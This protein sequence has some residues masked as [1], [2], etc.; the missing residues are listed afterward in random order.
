MRYWEAQAKGGDPMAQYE[1][2]KMQSSLDAKQDNSEVANLY[3]QAADQGIPGAARDLGVLYLQGNGVPQNVSKALKLLE[4]AAVNGDAQAS[5][6]MGYLYYTGARSDV[7]DE[8]KV[9][10]NAIVEMNRTKAEYFFTQAALKD[11]PESLFYLGEMQFDGKSPNNV[12]DDEN[13]KALRYYQR[14]ADNGYIRAFW[15]E[16]KLYENGAKGV[17]QSCPMAVEGYKTVAEAGRGTVDVRRGLQYFLQG[18][19]EA[20]WLVFALAAEEGYEIAQ[21]NAGKLAYLGFVRPTSNLNNPA[22]MRHF[23]QS[24][25]QGNSESV[26]FMARMFSK[27]LMAPQ[28]HQM[29]EQYFKQALGLGDTT[30]LVPL[31]EAMTHKKSPLDKSQIPFIIDTYRFALDRLRMEEDLARSSGQPQRFFDVARHALQTTVLKLKIMTL[32]LTQRIFR[33]ERFIKGIRL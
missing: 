16:A 30:V 1:L 31:T 6:F 15:A 23:R 28:N 2:A 26:G 4:W 32:S 27:G 25:A 10:S 14:A 3:S 12:T 33:N 24:A 21:Q 8:I 22:P 11:F 5:N 13:H 19:F 29:A 18:D 17:Q 9:Q 20:S 7:D